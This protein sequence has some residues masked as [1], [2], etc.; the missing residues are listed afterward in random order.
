MD[1][2]DIEQAGKDLLAAHPELRHRAKAVYHRVS[3]LLSN[4]K[5]KC[6]GDV[7]CV[8]PDD[9]FE[10]FYGYYDKSPWSADERYMLCMRAERTNKSVAPAEPIDILVLDT[11]DDYAPRK[12]GTSHSW[13]VQQGAMAQWLGPDFKTKVVYN[14]FRDGA[15]VSVIVNVEDG[16]E[17]VLPKPV[18]AVAADGTF[19]LTLDF[20]RLH[21][22]RPG[23]GYSNLPDSTEGQLVPDSPCIWRMNLT[24]G[25][26]RGL[27]KYAD[28][29]NFEPRPEM[30][31]AEHKVNHLMINPSG[32]RFMVL[33]RWFQRGRKYTRLVTANTDGSC[34]FNLSDD[35]FVSHCYWKSDSEI[36]SFM[37]RNATGD[38]YYLLSDLAHDYRLLWP[39]L[40]TDGHC[41]YSP[42][43]S[44]V[45]TDTY[46]DRHRLA[47][48]YICREDVEEPSKVATVFAPFSYDF[49][50]RCDLHP[51]WDRRGEKVCFD[52]VH[53]GKRGLY[54][55]GLGSQ[56]VRGGSQP[57]KADDAAEVGFSE[58]VE[59]LVSFVIPAHNAEK[60]LRRCVG[61]LLSQTNSSWECIIVNDG[62]TDDT[63]GVCESLLFDT[64]VTVVE[65]ENAGPGQ[66]RNSGI[67][68]AK[69][70]YISFLDSDDYLEV[71]FV[72]EIATRAEA[73]DPDV[74]YY[75]TA[76]ERED[77][78]HLRDSSISQYATDSREGFIT[79]QLS[80]SF[81][82]GATKAVS[83]AVLRRSGARFSS[84]D[85][86]EEALFTFQ[87]LIVANSIS[88]IER[89]LY[90]YVQSDEGQHKKG[91]N[92]P[93][94][95]AVAE[96]RAYLVANGLM[97]RYG[98]ALNNMALKALSMSLF[99]ISSKYGFIE[100]RRLMKD[101][102]CAYF[103]EYDLK[104]VDLEKV[105][106]SAALLHPLIVARSTLPIYL[107]SRLRKARA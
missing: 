18:Y 99:R 7:E 106:K 87:V 28:F 84:C 21:R 67:E 100:A 11:R 90:H 107:A 32:T 29:A 4:E 15:Y 75:E 51:R 2:T 74:I 26:V 1:F 64:R 105:A 68:R 85:V 33:H 37:R 78:S 89:P 57:P 94:R 93:L 82:W 50:T 80:G 92:D 102:I 31:G 35:D 72:E 45:V 12:I 14:D 3:Y 69:G 48:V 83:A 43:R 81:S 97:E 60:T 63:A 5:I 10:Y 42:D 13:S 54:V 38:H 39:G 19:A 98:K 22:L 58:S 30:E 24:T 77:G 52:S 66:A 27:F 91:D 40:K 46:P 34:L 88:F 61:S 65:Q 49:D 73:G 8:S 44:L 36:I 76:Y 55:V 9:R 70:R 104:D 95:E 86:G 62:S 16:S 23:Y 20:S 71:T 56:I 79:R 6:E 25:D 59:P 41:S 53:E 47:S 96:V 103:Q 17:R 101:Q